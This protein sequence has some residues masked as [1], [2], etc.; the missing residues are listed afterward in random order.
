MSETFLLIA[1]GNTFKIPTRGS[2]VKWSETQAI[3]DDGILGTIPLSTHCI[4]PVWESYGG[5]YY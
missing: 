1:I 2:F 5:I 3:N 4:L